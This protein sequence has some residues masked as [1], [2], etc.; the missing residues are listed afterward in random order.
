MA[1]LRAPSVQPSDTGSSALRFTAREP[2]RARLNRRHLSLRSPNLAD[3]HGQGCGLLF[4][5][6]QISSS[7]FGSD[8]PGPVSCDPPLVLSLFPTGVPSQVQV[9]SGPAATYVQAGSDSH[10]C[11]GEAAKA[12]GEK[13][14]PNPSASAMLVSVA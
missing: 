4:T 10:S 9:E 12:A 11:A 2:G 13:T 8:L 3:C 14:R 7:E 5:P 1:N 6:V